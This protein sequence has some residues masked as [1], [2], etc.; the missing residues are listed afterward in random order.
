MVYARARRGEGVG[1]H[2]IAHEL[3]IARG[4]LEKW[5]QQSDFVAVEIVEPQSAERGRWRGHQYG[6]T[7]TKCNWRWDPRTRDVVQ[8][9]NP[10]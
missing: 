3:G 10:Y 9:E 7:G 2:R 8:P 4:T 5:L 1:V 6:I